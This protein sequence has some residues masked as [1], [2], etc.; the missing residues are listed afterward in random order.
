M[1]QDFSRIKVDAENELNKLSNTILKK[2]T[3]FPNNWYGGYIELDRMDIADGNNTLFIKVN[4]AM[5]THLFLFTLNEM[6]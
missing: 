2:Q 5:E 1:K 6:K 4:I 3:V